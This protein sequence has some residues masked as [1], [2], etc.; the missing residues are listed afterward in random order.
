MKNLIEHFIQQFN[1]KTGKN[2]TDVSSKSMDL[3]IDC[4]WP[5]NVRELENAIE[6]AFVHCQNGLILP[7]HLPDEIQKRDSIID[8]AHKSD[9]PIAAAEKELILKTLD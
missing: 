2:I 8:I 4:S 3:L 7:E 9:D 1:Y 6:H 5:G